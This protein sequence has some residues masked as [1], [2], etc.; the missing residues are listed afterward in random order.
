MELEGEAIL[1][2]ILGMI[3]LDLAI[4]PKSRNWHYS[5]GEHN[6]QVVSSKQFAKIPEKRQTKGCLTSIQ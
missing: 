1:I 2:R 5:I 6:L 3:E 4:H